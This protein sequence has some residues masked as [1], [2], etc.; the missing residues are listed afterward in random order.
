MRSETQSSCRVPLPR[1]DGGGDEKSPPAQDVARLLDGRLAGTRWGAVLLGGVGIVALVVLGF[2]N[3]SEY[4]AMWFDEGI[5]LHVPKAIV[6]YGVYA[7]YSSE[8]FRHYG[9]TMSVGP[10]VMLPV[11]LALRIGG[12]G[13]W[14]A[15]AVMALY[16]VVA[17]IAFFA[18]ARRID[19]TR[20]AW[21]ATLLLV[22][23]PGLDL[24]WLGRQLLGEIPGLLFFALG[25]IVWLNAWPRP[26]LRR[27]AA[28]GALFGLAVVT[29]YQFLILLGPGLVLAWAA[30]RLYY[31]RLSTLVFV[32]PLGLAVACFA[33][34]QA[35]GILYLGPSIASENLRLM[36][37]AATGAALSFSMGQV[38]RSADYLLSFQLYASLLLPSLAY[39]VFRARERNAPAQIWATLLCLALPG[40]AWYLAASIGWPRYVFPAAAVAALL[41]ARLLGDLT[42]GFQCPGVHP[43]ARLDS[44]LPI[45][46]AF[47]AWVWFLCAVGPGLAAAAYKVLRPPH[48]AAQAMARY[49]DR[50]VSRTALIETW[51]PEMGFLT[52]HRYRYPPPEL[53]IDAVAFIWTSGPPPAT[54]YDFLQGESPDYVLEGEFARWVQL[55][56]AVKLNDNY[57]LRI[58]VGAYRLYER[59]DPDDD[60]VAAGS[61]RMPG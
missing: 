47:T 49:L 50:H 6:K 19:G 58:E 42:G 27:L 16:L 26:S 24:V 22:S 48:N 36:K 54:R 53:L 61:G 30:D 52:D 60:V 15:R 44:G 17:V 41:V 55:Y 28:A 18:L 12:I 31:R 39:S 1:P 14:Q 25:L 40:F 7:D 8:G 23:S 38:R 20:F 34:W 43:Q 13:L 29:K 3:L 45:A 46:L 32:V 21:A 9:P 11:A 59:R 5:H 4:P 10:T 37:A 57:R 2:F 51:E 56:P 35:V 33:A